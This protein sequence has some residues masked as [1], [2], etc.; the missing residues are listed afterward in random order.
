[1]STVVEIDERDEPSTVVTLSLCRTLAQ[2]AKLASRHLAVAH[3]AAKNA[4]LIGSAVALLDRRE[5]ILAANARDVAAAPGTGLNAAAIDRL[6][7]NPRR[8]EE[9]AQTLRDVAAATRPDW[10]DRCRRAAGPTASRSS[11]CACRSASFS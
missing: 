6:T 10:R 2:E 7:L 3:G 4:W 9:M 11:R 1:M 5:E 8:I